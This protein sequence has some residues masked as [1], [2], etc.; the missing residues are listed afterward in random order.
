MNADLEELYTN[1]KS[2]PNFSAKINDFLQQYD[3][4]SKNRKIVKRTFPRRRVIARFKDDLWQADLIEYPDHFVYKNN[5][6]KY[7]LLVIDVFSKFVYVEPIKKKTGDRTAE[8]I[9]KIIDKNNGPPVMLVTDGGKEFFN[10]QFQNVMISQNINHFRTPTVTKWKASVAER[11][12]RTIKTR[13]SRWMQKTQS[14]KW[15]EVLQQIVDNYN[16][17][18]HSSHKFPPQD[19]THENREVVYKRLYPKS[20][21][22]VECRLKVGDK[23]RKIKEKKDFEKGYTQNWSDE[24]YTIKEV[25]Q[26]HSVCWYKLADSEGVVIPGVYYY[27]TLNLVAKHDG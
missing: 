14:K 5:G 9:S 19:V 25:R 1:I 13:I 8:A 23:V 24:V 2:T 4:H 18:P 16:Q 6:F 27:Y 21:I 15:I 17:T 22:T 7:I 3:L 20:V 10:S 12:N 26:K 11:A